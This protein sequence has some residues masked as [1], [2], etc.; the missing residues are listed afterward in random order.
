VAEHLCSAAKLLARTTKCNVSALKRIT[1]FET[2]SRAKL[3]L[4]N[5]TATCRVW[6]PRW[7]PVARCP[8]RRPFFF[9]ATMLSRTSR[10]VSFE[11]VRTSFAA[12]AGA[13][14][15]VAVLTCLLEFE[16]SPPKRLFSRTLTFT[17]SFAKL[18]DTVNGKG[19]A[20]AAHQTTHGDDVNAIVPNPARDRHEDR[21]GTA[22][23][24]PGYPLVRSVH[25]C[26]SFRDRNCSRDDSES[27]WRTVPHT[28][29]SSV[30]AGSAFS[31]LSTLCRSGHTCCLLF[32]M[33]LGLIF[34]LS[35]RSR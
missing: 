19:R 20:R 3:E 25:F 23:C 27:W 21:N 11:T 7:A 14:A 26:T 34:L 17:D 8:F 32:L 24:C 22:G 4:R 15:A 28:S 16:C 5:R 33:T 13:S 31:G 2:L 18:S 12:R 30:V 35:R 9:L 1:A 6:L 10:V 29:R